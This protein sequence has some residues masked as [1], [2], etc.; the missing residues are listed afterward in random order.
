MQKTHKHAELI[1]AWAD[2][3]EVQWH[4][5]FHREWLDAKNPVW[6]KNRE[7]RVK[8][9]S[10]WTPRY[11]LITVYEDSFGT[12]VKVPEAVHNYDTLQQYV[13]EHENDWD[14]QRHEVLLDNNGNFTVVDCLFS[15]RTL[16]TIRMSKE[17][18][19]KL[20][21]MLNNREIEL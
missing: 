17:C 14:N 21:K 15:C 12:D 18:A 13:R 7:Y 20:C 16:G 5:D 19:E 9:K 10:K 4:S 2:G 1:K 11:R 8:P 6:N 3:A